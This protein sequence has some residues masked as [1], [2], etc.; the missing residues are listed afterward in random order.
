MVHISSAVV[1]L[2]FQEAACRGLEPLEMT[3]GPEGL[4]YNGNI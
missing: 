1:F 2:R 3:G 4:N